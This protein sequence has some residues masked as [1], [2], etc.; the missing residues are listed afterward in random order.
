M[1]IGLQCHIF[2]FCRYMPHGIFL[3]GFT[4]SLIAVGFRATLIS[5]FSFMS[6]KTYPRKFL[7]PEVILSRSYLTKCSIYVVFQN[8]ATY[9]SKLQ[10]RKWSQTDTDYLRKFVT[11]LYL[12]SVAEDKDPSIRVKMHQTFFFIFTTICLTSP[13]WM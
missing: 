13:E 4:Y 2:F 12:V 3:I 8:H 9:W 5:L 1:P 11:K 6:Q 7:R 10:L